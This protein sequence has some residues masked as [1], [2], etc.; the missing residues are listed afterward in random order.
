MP[1]LLGGTTAAAWPPHS[2]SALT[3]SEQASVLAAWADKL[4]I[5]DA[6]WIG[7]SLGCNT[8]AHVAAMR[9]DLVR[10]AVYIGPLWSQT[11]PRLFRALLLD[12]FREPLALWPFVLRA[13]WRCGLA[14]WF[15]SI[16]HAMGDIAQPPPAA[17]R[18][19]AGARDPLPALRD[20][21]RVP[22]AHACHFSFAEVTAREIRRSGARPFPPPA[23]R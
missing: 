11:L 23:R 4:G 7:H 18:M 1:P 10:D 15:A 21:T 19:L 2:T 17:G 5:R 12:A 22:G 6:L 14:R 13:Y 9:P 16:R 8:V 3:P 20:L